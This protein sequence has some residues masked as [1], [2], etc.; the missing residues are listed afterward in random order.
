MQINTISQA[1]DIAR[2]V[3][4]TLARKA[5]VPLLDFAVHTAL[6]A[7]DDLFQRVTAAIEALQTFIG[8]PLSA[9]QA[10]QLYTELLHLGW[11]PNAAEWPDQAD[12]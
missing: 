7:D 2:A 6:Y 11:K 12:L 4:E 10:M 3:D 9:G 8:F 1:N 5:L